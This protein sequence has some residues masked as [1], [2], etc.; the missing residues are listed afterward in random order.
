[1]CCLNAPSGHACRLPVVRGTSAIHFFILLI[2]EVASI[3]TRAATM[4]QGGAVFIL[5]IGEQAASD[6]VRT[7]CP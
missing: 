7:E 3:V 6:C 1:M 5:D 2:L 4:A